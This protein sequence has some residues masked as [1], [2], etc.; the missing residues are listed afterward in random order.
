[1]S[2]RILSKE[3]VESIRY[4]YAPSSRIDRMCTSH[5]ALRAEVDD[6]ACKLKEA[7]RCHEALTERVEVL[8]KALRQMCKDMDEAIAGLLSMERLDG[9]GVAGARAKVFE[10]MVKVAR[11][12]LAAPSLAKQPPY[13]PADEQFQD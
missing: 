1:M 2:D 8:E 10:H 3:E 7:D 5:E 9:D 6:L 11:A 12:A 13:S 4:H